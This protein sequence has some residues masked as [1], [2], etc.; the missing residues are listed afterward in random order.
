VTKGK[1]IKL[2]GLNM[3][4]Q[5]SEHFNQIVNDTVFTPQGPL[6][7]TEQQTWEEATHTLYCNDLHERSS[8]IFQK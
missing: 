4:G 7:L 1:H 3:K 6:C 2:Q 8:L 5:E